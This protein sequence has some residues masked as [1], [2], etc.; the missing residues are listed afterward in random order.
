MIS[1]IE[2]P[3]L[4]QNEVETVAISITAGEAIKE[5]NSLS[6]KTIL[7]ESDNNLPEGINSHAD[8]QLLH[9][10]KNK[11]MIPKSNEQL[12]GVLNNK[13]YS[14]ELTENLSLEYPGDVLLNAKIVGD[15]IICNKKTVSRKV[16]DYSEKESMKIIDVNQGYAGCSVCV[17]N[18]NA[19]I[20]DDISI[21]R[22]AQNF[23]NDVTLIKKNTIRLKNYNYGFIGG[24]CGKISKNEIAFNG[25]LMSHTDYKLI[26]DALNRNNIKAVELH[27]GILEDIGGI[28]PLTEKQHFQP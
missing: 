26:A 8:L 1:F 25:S 11:I 2:K 24:C 6:I 28:L 12:F 27:N 19:I 15:Y 18:E 14:I 9:L 4:P 22:A 17:L 23:L 3:N 21:F 20:T 7:I 16:L 5:L 13:G 10:E